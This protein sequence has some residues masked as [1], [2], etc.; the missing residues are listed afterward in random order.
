MKHK[1]LTGTLTWG[2]IT[3]VSLLQTAPAQAFTFSQGGAGVTI[4]A[5]DVGKDFWSVFNGQVDDQGI[6]ST[7]VEGLSSQAN[8][9]VTSF[10]NNQIVFDILLENTSHD[11]ITTSVVSVLGF[12]SN[13]LVKSAT[14]TG[15]FDIVVLNK[16]I[17]AF[18]GADVNICFKEAG[19]NKNCNGGGNGG[20]DLGQ[21]AFFTAT[22]NFNSNISSGLFLDEFGVRYQGI[23]GEINGQVVED[24]SGTGVGVVPTPALLPGLIGM[25][26]AAL[27]KKKQAKEKEA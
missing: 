15:D 1:L 18:E 24:F 5:D 12:R 22:L 10:T 3:A 26:I 2:A 23:E 19:G 7:N 21:S 13:P 17:N 11:P 6:T 4:T 16:T 27:R 8:F 20:V 14:S 25:G 9:K